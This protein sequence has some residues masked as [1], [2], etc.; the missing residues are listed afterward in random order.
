MVDAV[1]RGVGVSGLSRWLNDDFFGVAFYSWRQEAELLARVRSAAPAGMRAIYGTDYEP[2]AT[3]QMLSE[4][5]RL[6]EGT[7]H[8]ATVAA[9]VDEDERRRVAAVKSRDLGSL[10]GFGGDPSIGAIQDVWASRPVEAERIL[11]TLKATLE[12]NHLFAS[13]QRWLSNRHRADFQRANFTRLSRAI[14]AAHPDARFLMKYG[15]NHL[16]RG[17]SDAKV[18]DLGTLVPEMAALENRKCFQL[19]VLGGAGAMHAVVDPASFR[20]AA[21]AAGAA[22]DYGLGMFVQLAGSLPTVFDL[23]LLRALANKADASGLS[24]K[25][26]AMI[27][28]FDALVIIPGASASSAL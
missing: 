14:W 3:R 21:E 19:A 8:R 6:A 18:F 24:E 12:I 22:M 11:G 2:F 5:L 16:R 10:F 28:G 23:T 13:G 7:S 1:I 26:V 25:A 20:S 4:L 27:N 17:L 9:M 15:A